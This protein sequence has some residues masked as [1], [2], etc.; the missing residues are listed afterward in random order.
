MSFRE[1]VFEIFHECVQVEREQIFGQND[2]MPVSWQNDAR[3][4][5]PGVLGDEYA[6]EG[7]VF[8]GI[9]P[10]GGKDTYSEAKR[11]RYGDDRLYPA[12]EQFKKAKKED[13]SKTFDKLNDIAQ[14]VM[15]NWTIWRYISRAIKAV[16]VSDRNE[17]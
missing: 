3:L 13:I 7:V 5:F 14:D 16:G 17:E 4:M 12:M 2:P 8:M 9:N 15:S 1:K 11:K 6:S 10:G